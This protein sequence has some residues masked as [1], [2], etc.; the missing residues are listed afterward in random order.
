MASFLFYCPCKVAEIGLAV[1][2]HGPN[3]DGIFPYFLWDWIRQR[4]KRAR[5]RH[6]GEIV[7]MVG[8]DRALDHRHGI[9]HRLIQKER[10][11]YEKECCAL[12]AEE[13]TDG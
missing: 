6:C 1:A 10:R 11:R 9:N 13:Q 5:C 7:R 2:G 12:K 4:N 3:G 8:D